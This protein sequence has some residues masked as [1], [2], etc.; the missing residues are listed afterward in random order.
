MYHYSTTP[1]LHYSTTHQIHTRRDLARLFTKAGGLK[2]L[3]K[4]LHASLHHDPMMNDG[5]EEAIKYGKKMAHIFFSIASQTDRVVKTMISGT[6]EQTLNAMEM[7]SEG[8]GSLDSLTS[9]TSMASM[10]AIPGVAARYSQSTNNVIA[11]NQAA[12]PN[13]RG[14]GGGRV[15]F[16]GVGNDYQP[17]NGTNGM[18]NGQQLN[19]MGNKNSILAQLL[20][21]LSALDKD[22]DPNG[23]RRDILLMILKSFGELSKDS[24][25]IGPLIEAKTMSTVI[26]F[27][28]SEDED[29]QYIVVLFLWNMTR[30]NNAHSIQARREAAENGAIPVLKRLLKYHTKLNKSVFLVE[31]ICKFPNGADAAT[32]FEMKKHNMAQFYIDM[33]KN[34]E[35]FHGFSLDALTALARWIENPEY[36]Q[37]LEFILCQPDNITQLIELF[38]SPIAN[39]NSRNAVR[40]KNVSSILEAFKTLVKSPRISDALGDSN[41]FLMALGA[42]FQNDYLPPEIVN[43]LLKMLSEMLGRLTDNP[44]SK[45]KCA[46]T[47]LP[48][49]DKVFEKGK[50]NGKYAVM[51]LI[52]KEVIPHISLHVDDDDIADLCPELREILMG[53]GHGSLPVDG[54]R[55]D[56]G[57]D[58]SYNHI[59]D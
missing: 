54:R 32:L 53:T 55:H 44:A 14:Q 37:R 48:I 10:G 35:Q 18:T 9:I 3:L 2:R 39:M 19:G 49:I 4:V 7:S 11:S 25:C 50:K 59:D 29:I 31:T 28:E 56:Y 23:K 16:N 22:K 15:G 40:S 58:S 17:R 43:D 36:V 12:K 52:K 5:F 27:L 26:P 47:I 42:W 33:T 20:G 24:N 21:L 13:Y 41:V 8:L 46:K 51:H 1:L 38:K 57:L 34:D 45:K 30:V 6:S